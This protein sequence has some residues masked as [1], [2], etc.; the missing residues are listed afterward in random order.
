MNE[1]SIKTNRSILPVPLREDSGKCPV[2]SGTVRVHESVV[3]SIVP[4]ALQVTPQKSMKSGR[5]RSRASATA[6][7][8]S[9][10]Q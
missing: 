4:Q 5:R 7:A 1:E 2:P 9:V 10:C 6:E 8:T 3:A